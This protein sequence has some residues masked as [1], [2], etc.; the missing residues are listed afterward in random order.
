[1]PAATDLHPSVNID[2]VRT[3][4]HVVPININEGKSHFFALHKLYL[5]SSPNESKLVQ[6]NMMSQIENAQCSS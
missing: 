5:R 4:A 6:V 2:L 3:V 1:M